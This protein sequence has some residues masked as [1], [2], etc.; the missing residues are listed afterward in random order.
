MFRQQP[1]SSAVV[2]NKSHKDGVFVHLELNLKGKA[3]SQDFIGIIC[4]SQFAPRLYQSTDNSLM[5]PTMWRNNFP[6]IK[7]DIL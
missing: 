2:A 4:D 3:E 7:D 1:A 5:A 6:P